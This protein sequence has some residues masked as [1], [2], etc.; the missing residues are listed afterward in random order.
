MQGVWGAGPEREKDTAERQGSGR[1]I[2][3][4]Y[5]LPGGRGNLKVKVASYPYRATI[6]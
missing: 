6:H 5:I 3:S 1:K 4:K 2:N